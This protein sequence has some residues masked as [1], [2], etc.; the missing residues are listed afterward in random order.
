MFLRPM[1][2]KVAKGD[3]IA[4]ILRSYARCAC[5]RRICATGSR[6]DKASNNMEELPF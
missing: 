2:R 5:L 3:V 1:M 4:G 6:W